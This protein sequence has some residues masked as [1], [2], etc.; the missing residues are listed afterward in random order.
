[1]L[2]CFYW[3]VCRLLEMSSLPVRDLASI[4][5]RIL[6]DLRRLQRS[7]INGSYF[8]RQENI[9]W[10]EWSHTHTHTLTR[11]RTRCQQLIFCAVNA[12]WPFRT[13]HPMQKYISWDLI[14]MGEL[15]IQ[16][17]NKTW[18]SNYIHWF[19]RDVIIHHNF[20][21]LAN[22]GRAWTSNKIQW[23]YMGVITYPCFKLNDVLA[24]V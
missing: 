3:I 19:L 11:T 9:R 16:I 15:Y 13:E 12:M 6:T 4:W 17:E 20:N 8:T 1:M 10:T 22:Q 23:I 14:I 2:G 7:R 24:N 21:G 5:N 18:I